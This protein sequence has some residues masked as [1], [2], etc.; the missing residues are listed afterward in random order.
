MDKLLEFSLRGSAFIELDALLK[1][2]G[3]AET[4]DMAKIAIADGR[5]TVDG[6]VEL[7]RRCKIRAGQRVAFAGHTITVA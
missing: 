4:G 6:T 7:R 1:L 2:T 5:V 3:L